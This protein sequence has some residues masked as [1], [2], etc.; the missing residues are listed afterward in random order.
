MSDRSISD[1]PA[2]LP[3]AIIGAGPVGLAAAAHAVRRGLTPV[4]FERGAAVGASLRDWA[5]VRVFTPWRYN[6]DAAARALLEESGWTA[7]DDDALPTG[8]GI[9][10]DYLEPLAAHP[11][12]APHLR[13]GAEV[14][15]IT[16]A[17]LDK[18]TTPGRA[19]APLVVSWRDRDGVEQRTAAR[20]VL[21]ASGTWFTP[22][23]MGVDGLPVPGERDATDRIAYGIPDVRGAARGAYAGATVLVVGSG[24]SAMNVVLDLLALQDEA[25]G[26]RVLWALRRNRLARL[27]GGGLN[28]QLPA[29]GALG[30]AA[31]K[32]IEEGRLELLSPYAAER[33]EPATDGLRIVG[34]LGGQPHVVEVQRV[35]VATGL[36]PD[37]S[38][39]RELRVDPDPLVEAPPKLAPLIDPNLHSCG[40]VP[41]H[42]V[43]ELA[44]PEPNF[45]IVG[46][47][48]YGRAPTFLMATG[49]EQVRSVMAEIAGDH[50]AARDVH[51]VLP[52]T[53]VCSTDALLAEGETTAA[54]CCGTPAPAPAK[55]SGCCAKVA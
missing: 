1:L 43:E 45:Y 20:A 12:I 3:V 34:R 11:A 50:E 38:I 24:H 52:E 35:V 4:L 49:Y 19:A 47:K 42:G 2:D 23:P 5:H 9:V 40:T 15:A 22:N 54:G 18:L 21:D 51:L 8:G 25:P 30:V 10:R 41:P 36:R 6:I 26:T 55:P 27:L 37:L 32:A 33:V 14:L 7:P 53:G 16:R 13:L 48:S 44:H 28:D 39:L 46:G 17:G 29:R 31:T